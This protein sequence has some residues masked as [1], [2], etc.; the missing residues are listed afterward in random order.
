MYEDRTFDNLL[1]EGLKQI[2]DNILK[3]EGS[4]VYAPVAVLAYELEKLYRQLDYLRRQSDPE[5]ADYD[6]L[7]L[8]ARARG[9]LPDEA[10]AARFRLVADGKVF[11]GARFSLSGFVFTVTGTIDS[12]YIVTC[13]TTGSAPNNLRGAVTPVDYVEGLTGA[14]I[15][16]VLAAGSDASTQ[17]ELLERYLESFRIQAFGGNRTDYIQHLTAFEGVGGCRVF[18]CWNG[19]GTV[20]CV[21]I[22]SDFGTLSELLVSQIQEKMCPA[23]LMGYGIAPIGHDVTVQSV[24]GVKINVTV[25]I[26]YADGKSWSDAGEAVKKAIGDYLLSIRQ[27]WAEAEKESEETVVYIR[28]IEA[29]ILT[30]PDVVD[31]ANTTL[32]GDSGNLTLKPEEIPLDGEVTE[33]AV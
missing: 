15:T 32:N 12:D 21:L 23:P 29:A 6:S 26:T 25:Q 24:S 17:E 5:T 2:P 4:F 9:I 22:G 27:E 1:S 16:E 28:R 10:S 11:T 31:I 8:M 14:S 3:G 33:G 18:P 19:A 13:R 7:I 30:V 20:K